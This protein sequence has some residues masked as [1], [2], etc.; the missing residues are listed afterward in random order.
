MAN[1]GQKFIAELQPIGRRADITAG[2]TLLS[3]AQSVG[4]E[5]QA[6]CGGEGTCGQ[7]KVRLTAGSLSAPTLQ[8]SE[9]LGP[10]LLACG[11]R[12]AC[13]AMPGSDV[14][15]EIPPES[16]TSSQR[17]QLD[18][19]ELGVSL[20][21]L[22]VPFDL[23]VDASLPGKLQESIIEAVGQ[24]VRP[25]PESLEQLEEA[26]QQFAGHVRVAVSKNLHLSRLSASSWSKPASSALRLIS[27]QRN[28]RLTSW[29]WKRAKR[30]P[31]AD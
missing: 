18:G 2:N 8:E 20:G 21:P 5:L 11:Y 31:N 23:A 9:K 4:V 3:A 29:I 30:L 13:Q 19:R 27:G 28:S 12:L 22:V 15:L 6:V 7:C 17:V 14:T 25:A 10:E 24:D 26:A 1:R 16:L